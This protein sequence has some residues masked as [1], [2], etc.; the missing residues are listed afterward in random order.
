MTKSVLDEL[1]PEP[2]PKMWQ[3]CNRL[4]W[5]TDDER[6]S[7]FTTLSDCRMKRAREFCWM[8]STCC[9][10]LSAL[11]S[12]NEPKTSPT[13]SPTSLLVTNLGCLGTTLRLGSSRLSGRLQLFTATEESATNWQQCEINVDCS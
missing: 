8:R 7:M 6:F 12:R 3:K 1:R 9:T 4:S 2:R 10:L 5:K 11:S 13:S